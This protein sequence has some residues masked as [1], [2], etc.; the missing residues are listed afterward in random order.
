MTTVSNLQSESDSQEVPPCKVNI[1]SPVRE[2]SPLSEDTGKVSYSSSSSSK[3]FKGPRYK[4]RLPISEVPELM[5]LCEEFIATKNVTGL[6]MIA[7]QRGLPPSLRYKIWPVLL[8]YHPYVQHPYIEPDFDDD[9]DAEEE[10]ENGHKNNNNDTVNDHNDEHNT[11]HNK[12]EADT[13]KLNIPYKEIKFDLK[14][15]TRYTERYKPQSM[16]LELHDLFD[17]QDK[18]FEAIEGAIVRF[19][20]KWGSIVKYNSGLT[21]IAMGLAEW[22][23][24]LENSEYV[25]CGRDDIAKN[26]TK[27]RNVN[28]NYFERFDSYD[29]DISSNASLT[30][31]STPSIS[32]SPRSV[33]SLATSSL[34]SDDTRTSHSRHSNDP[35]PFKPMNFAEVYERMVLVILH[36]PDPA[37]KDTH[38]SPVTTTASSH[39]SDSTSPSDMKRKLDQLPKFG[40]TIEDR[41]SFFFFGLRKLMPELH[42]YLSDEDSLKGNWILWWLKY[43]G[44]KVWS[45][46]DRGRTWDMLLGFRVN[47]RHFERDLPVLHKLTDEQMRLL[48]PDLFWY[49]EVDDLSVNNGYVDDSSLKNPLDHHGR[50]SSILTLLNQV[51]VGSSELTPT[52]ASLCISGLENEDI[53]ALPQLPF[54]VIDPHIQMIFVSLAFL[55]S[56]EFTITELDQSEIIQLFNRLSSLKTSE[57]RSFVSA[58]GNTIDQHYHPIKKSNRDI[59]NIILEAGELWRKF[60]YMEMMVDNT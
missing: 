3:D 52:L 49:P 24:P 58:D 45:R 35:Y 40:G 43:C 37:E 15:Y 51:S 26:G 5:T 53:D 14:K 50:S 1:S 23:P 56:K 9:D 29:S 41:I 11:G 30:V 60:I 55:K 27:L 47:C 25:L 34:T 10:E 7:R 19:V 2:V 20:K 44:S 46:Y 32:G 33:S 21:W 4:G 36:T 48:G 39:T 12:K 8:R 28:D 54:S 17:I 31:D 59:E 42:G 18:M 38:L 6:A 57:I 16:T 22:I 13:G